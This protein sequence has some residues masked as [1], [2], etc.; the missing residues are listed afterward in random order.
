MSDA[1]M[2][3]RRVRWSMESTGWAGSCELAMAVALTA[4]RIS[5]YSKRA[6]FDS[7]IEDSS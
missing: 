1:L 2:F 6:A 7:S 5:A 3:H 4:D